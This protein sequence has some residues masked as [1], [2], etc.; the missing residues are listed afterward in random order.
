MDGSIRC[1]ALVNTMNSGRCT[2]VSERVIVQK[3]RTCVPFPHAESMDGFTLN[4]RVQ[5]FM[6]PRSMPRSIT[7]AARAHPTHRIGIPASPDVPEQ[8]F[9]ASGLPPDV[10]CDVI[11]QW[12]RPRVLAG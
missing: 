8:A 6:T 10:P 4:A 9:M 12:A 3:V 5:G 1:L 2:G 7:A 11:L